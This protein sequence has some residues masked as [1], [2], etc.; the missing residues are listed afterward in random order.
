MIFRII[1][2][3]LLLFL[4]DIKKPTWLK[5]ALRV[6]IIITEVNLKIVLKKL[7]PWSLRVFYNWWYIYPTIKSIFPFMIHLIILFAFC[8]WMNPIVLELEKINFVMLLI[9]SA[10]LVYH[11]VLIIYI[12]YLLKSLNFI[13][14]YLYL[15]ESL[16]KTQES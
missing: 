10:W 1:F 9:I 13:P 16:E 14:L 3:Y 8:N 12:L 5:P 2:E 6:L 11:L 4:V 15:I 7:P